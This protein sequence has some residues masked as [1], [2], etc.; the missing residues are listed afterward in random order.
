V[1]QCTGQD[2]GAFRRQ[3]VL[4]RVLRRMRVRHVGTLEEYLSV[5][6]SQTGEARALHDELLLKV[7]DFFRDT[8]F[9]ATVEQVLR[10][11]L[12]RTQERV[13]I[14]TIG[15]STG[16]EA[17]SIGMLLMELAADS[18]P[19]QLQLFASDV[20]SELLQQAREGVYPQ[21]IAASVSQERL[22]K[23]FTQEN[24]RYRVRRELRDLVT[25]AS[26]DLFQD[27][28]YSH[29]DLIVCRK[30]LR[31]L[32]PAMRRAALNLFYYALEPHG[33]LIIDAQDEVELHNLFTRDGTRPGLL[34]RSS[35]PRQV[36]HLP[37]GVK[38]FARLPEERGGT[39]VGADGADAVA[40][41]QRAVE[42][43][44]PPSLL[45]DADN[46]VVHFS[47]TAARYV[48]LPGGDLTADALKL[49]PPG[50]RRR[51]K[52]GLEVVRR[53]Q[54]AWQSDPFVVL[55]DGHARRMTLRI[56]PTAPSGPSGPS[57]QGP[58]LLLVVFDDGGDPRPLDRT[59]GEQ[60]ML[61]QVLKL[62]SELEAV[63]E[64]LALLSKD[65]ASPARAQAA[66][67]PDQELYSLVEELDGAREELQ[68]VNEELISV[69][70]ENQSRIETLAGLSNDLQHLLDTSG[71]ATVLLNRELEIL[72]FTPLAANLLRL[73]ESDIGRPLADLKHNLR[74]GKL[75][76]DMRPVV[77]NLA[78]LEIEVESDE[79]RWYLV[80]AQPYRTAHRGLEGATLLFIDITDRKRAE[81]ALREADR[82]KEE[83]LA[84]LAHEL[85]NPLAPLVAGLELLRKLPD[86]RSLVERVAATM[87]RQTKQLVRLVDDL[88]EVV[89]IN[90]DKLTLR[91]QP[92]SVSEVVR[93][94]VAATRPIMENLEHELTVDLPEEP[95]SVE[96]DGARLTQVI[97]NLLNNAARYT[98]PRGHIALKAA[99][100]DENV[101]ITV[102]DNGRGLS[103]QSLAN[104]FEM[105]YQ[106]GESAVSNTGLGIGLTLARKLVE[107]HGGTI[108][109]QSRGPGR[110]STFTVTLPLAH[111]GITAAGATGVQSGNGQA[112]T[113]HRVLIVDDNEDAAETLRLL[114]K[115]LGG[116]DVR[117]ASNG[118]EA[119]ATAAK[120]LPDLVLLDLGMPGMDGYELA[121]RM[122]AEPWGKGA[123]LVALTGWGQ[124]QHRR[125]SQEAGFDRH[126]IKPADAD[127]LRSV[128][129]SC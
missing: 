30:L 41:F 88:L 105:F 37:P 118:P 9:Y 68:A 93:D 87:A 31:V 33:V 85:R 84:V 51:L 24:G 77:E 59:L 83:F 10:E 127:A 90:E 11:S 16:E 39:A 126:M 58:E 46:R 25:F 80:R 98:P 47:E 78:D 117:T 60:R 35:G 109:A 21:E 95:L 29:L 67:Q 49:L 57:A 124:E 86:D 102:E 56:D 76:A 99:R 20:A 8:E 114:M 100:H 70:Q 19:R 71:F 43:Y 74:Y 82:R 62:Q 96:G 123:L 65:P 75:V 4:Q 36:L 2:F 7:T 89:R 106:A 63:H 53:E 92:V 32:Q 128:L 119:L 107:M 15:C 54:R 1:R 116:G 5:L 44:V 14:W 12:Q 48:R 45:L 61:D 120:L 111:P 27:P 91:I 55:L 103:S 18:G 22:E 34:R 81:L 129:D 122:R 69:N 28:P 13:R 40:R 52:E 113:P 108:G 23:F 125:R 115:S 50:I 17:Y 112:A 64:Q 26:H 110:G 79:G 104:V 97:G 6:Q 121:R 42:R 72:R 66:P 73:K 3:R 94:A 101:V 38:S